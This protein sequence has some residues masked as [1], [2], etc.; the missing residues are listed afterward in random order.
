MEPWGEE[1]LWDG[2][3]GPVQYSVTVLEAV[4]LLK[5]IGEAVTI[6]CLW[7]AGH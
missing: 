2:Q 6:F 5:N 1:G 3:A 4:E 7:V